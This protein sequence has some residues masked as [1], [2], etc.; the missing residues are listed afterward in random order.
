MHVYLRLSVC[1]QCKRSEIPGS[2]VPAAR[3]RVYVYVCVCV[4]MHTY[5]Y[6]HTYID[7]CMYTC[8]MCVCICMVALG[9]IWFKKHAHV[10]VCMMY[11]CM[12]VCIPACTRRH[13][14]QEGAFV[15]VC[16][17]SG[18]VDCLYRCVVERTA[19]QSTL[20]HGTLVHRH[21][22]AVGRKNALVW[23]V[24]CVLGVVGHGAPAEI[25]VQC[26]HLG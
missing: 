19:I 25:S 14:A 7:V 15:E 11:V 6:T 10:C 26:Q 22:S 9:N 2:R 21:V 1:V 18:V 8:V 23:H 13:L 5:I 3:K 20:I 17:H 24:A 16:S 12:Y 4:C